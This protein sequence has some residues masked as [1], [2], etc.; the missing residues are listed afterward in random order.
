[1]METQLCLV[2]GVAASAVGGTVVRAAQ[3]PYEVH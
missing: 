1:M 2:L 3:A